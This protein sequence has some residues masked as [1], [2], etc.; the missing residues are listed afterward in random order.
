MSEKI[1]PALTPEEWANH[2]Q[3][4]RRVALANFPK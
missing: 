3:R 4:S 2:R 1:E